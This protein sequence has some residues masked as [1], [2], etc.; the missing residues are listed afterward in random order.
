L[1]QSFLFGVIGLGCLMPLSTIFQLYRDGQFY[2][3]RKPLTALKSLT[4]FITL[5][6][7][8]YTL[9]WGGFKLT[10]LVVIGSDCKGKV[11]YHTIITTVAPASLLTDDRNHKPW[12]MSSTERSKIKMQVLMECCYSIYKWKVN[13]RKIEVISFVVKLHS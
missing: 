11:N 8:E 12:N 5:C 4:N 1:V 9:P 7:I 6:C 2:W 3:W 13:N 10:T